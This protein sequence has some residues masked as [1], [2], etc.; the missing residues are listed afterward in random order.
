LLH[1][2]SGLDSFQR[3]AAGEEQH[4]E[5]YQHL[6]FKFHK[7]LDQPQSHPLQTLENSRTLEILQRIE[8]LEDVIYVRRIFPNT[9]RIA[10]RFQHKVELTKPLQAQAITTTPFTVWEVIRVIGGPRLEK[11]GRDRDLAGKKRR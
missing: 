4:A 2:S 6:P 9:Q 10:Q 3:N 8:V 5:Q 7:G 1:G 11:T